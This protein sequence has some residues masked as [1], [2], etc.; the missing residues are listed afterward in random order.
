[1]SAYEGL[2]DALRE[3]GSTVKVNGDSATAQC[4][5]HADK[6]PSL[7]LRAIEGRVLVFCH[8]GC[9]T[10]DIM[11]CLGL[12]MSALFDD[13]KGATYV[14]SDGRKV[15]RDADKK[16]RQRGNTKGKALFHVECIGDAEI[17]YVPEGENDVLA[18]ESVGG[19]AV[20]NAMG[21]G[22]AHLFDWSPLKGRNVVIIADRDDA[23]HAH[24]DQVASILDD[25]AADVR[26]AEAKMGKDA[27]D[28]IAAGHPLGELVTVVSPLLAGL[29]S[30]ADLENMTFPELVEHVPNL[31]TEGFG[32]LAGSP[33]VGKSWLATGIALACAQ[34]GRV[35]G[36]IKVAPRAVLLLALED[37]ERRLQQRM[38]KLNGDDPLPEKLDY[39]TVIE[40]GQV[41]PTIKEWLKAHRHDDNPPLV[42]LDTFGKV[43]PQRKPGEDAYIADYQT[44]SYIKRVADS[45][46]GAAILVV[47]HDRKASSEDWLHSVSGTQGVTGSADY[48]LLLT[49]KRKSAEG[50]LSVT[51]RDIRENEYATLLIDGIWKLEGGSFGTAAEA[52]ET[53]REREKLG[54]RALEVLAFV[55]SRTETRAA[56]LS[57]L[58]IGQDQARV[59]LNRL[60]DSGRI[61]KFGRG[62]Y[63]P[64]LRVTS[65]TNDEENEDNVTNI[66]NITNPLDQENPRCKHC[67]DL[68]LLDESRRRGYCSKPKCLLEHQHQQPEGTHEER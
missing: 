31:I 18:I 34:G 6:R 29:R 48:I 7:G 23:G 32:I 43:R 33:K 67:D 3:H 27:A 13:R 54:D 50:L 24:A 1:M 55:N 20:C 19:A 68:L 16:F 4:P 44:G 51:G 59:C 25:I 5:A 12:S 61:N 39:L 8:A 60:A 15:H 64:L 47:H 52:V 26:I 66:T 45:V 36:T 53:R 14:Y 63:K 22:K 62:R 35:F 58:G 17:V 56:D 46:P 21:A 41:M 65:V 42:V 10:E 2:L 9:L 49:R 37:G 30:A 38:W 40:P 11:A 57:E 28:H